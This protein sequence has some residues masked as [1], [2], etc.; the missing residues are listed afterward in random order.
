VIANSR[1]FIVFSVTASEQEPIFNMTEVLMEI[2]LLLL[3][4]RGIDT[5][6]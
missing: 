1:L 3:H 2:E 4:D 6:N 5:K